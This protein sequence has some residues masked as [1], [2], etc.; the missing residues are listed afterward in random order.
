MLDARGAASTILVE[1]TVIPLNDPPRA[2]NDTGFTTLEDT[3]LVI[4]PASILANDVDPNGDE[5]TLDSVER[6]PLNGKVALDADGLIIFTPRSD[7]NG[8]AGFE[9]TISDGRGGF[10]EGFVAI[11]V[12]PRND[13]AILRDDI[14]EGLE[15]EPIFVLAA[16]AFGN[17]IEPE[18]DV[19][20]FE[21]V[22]VLGV[23]V[24]TYLS[25][26]VVQLSATLNDGSDLPDWLNFTEA[27]LTFRGVM[28]DGIAQPI[29]VTINFFYPS[30][31]IGF[32]RE[33]S[34]G[35]QDAVALQEGIVYSGDLADSY[36]VRAPFTAGFEFVAASLAAD[37]SVSVKLAEADL[38]GSF[39]LPSWLAFDAAT[40][41]FTGTPPV[42]AIAIYLT[43][44]LVLREPPLRVSLQSLVT[45]SPLTLRMLPWPCARHHL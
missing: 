39:D 19:L 14:L 2:Y 1:L 33:L 15:D 12:L 37:V 35:L 20:F 45:R 23:L 29:N 34:F 38:A 9:Y 21:S 32:S 26:P 44:N 13:P 42:D 6:F 40:L 27:D 7:Y 22:A 43:Y 28:P 17:D 18:G 31:G 41:T 30:D 3:A 36:K 24:P 5:I 25:D 10:D 16:E 8:E 11:T 4:D